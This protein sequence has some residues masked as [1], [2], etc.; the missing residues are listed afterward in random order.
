MLRSGLT[1]ATKV[2]PN[3]ET[4]GLVLKAIR[5][6]LDKAAVVCDWIQET[7]EESNSHKWPELQPSSDMGARDCATAIRSISPEDILE[8]LRKA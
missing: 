5:L 6:T 4:E 7:E 1:P 2:R 8:E 3:E